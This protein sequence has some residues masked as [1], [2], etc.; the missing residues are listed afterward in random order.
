ML[1]RYLPITH[2]DHEVLK[3]IQPVL[4][5]DFFDFLRSGHYR[6]FKMMALEFLFQQIFSEIDTFASFFGFDPV[7]Y[8]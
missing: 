6:E 3:R 7:F 8:L 4:I 1:G 5:I 2:T